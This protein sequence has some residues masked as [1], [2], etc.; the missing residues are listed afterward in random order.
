MDDRKPGRT[1]DDEVTIF[2]STGTALEDVAAAAALYE[3]A[4]AAGRGVRFAFSA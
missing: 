1:S 2:D 3:K 4:W